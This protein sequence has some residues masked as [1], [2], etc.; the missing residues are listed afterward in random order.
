MTIISI[1]T[2]YHTCFII[3]ILRVFRFVTLYRSWNC[4]INADHVW[5]DKLAEIAQTVDALGDQFRQTMRAG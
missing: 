3:L 5:Q 1:S 2:H 4:R